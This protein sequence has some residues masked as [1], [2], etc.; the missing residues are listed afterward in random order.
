MGV[1]GQAPGSDENPPVDE[2]RL[3]RKQMGRHQREIQRLRNTVSFRLGKH[4]TDA[5]RQPWRMPLLP[6]TFPLFALKLGLERLGKRAQRGTSTSDSFLLNGNN[7]VVLFPTNGVGFGH[8]TRMYAMAR[9]LRRLDP[10]TEI[11][12]FTPM[13][14]LHVPYADG[15]ATYHMAG[16]Y[17]FSDMSASTWNGLVEEHLMMVLETHQPKMFVFDGAY[18]YRG[19][20]NAIARF[21]GMKRVWVRRGMFRK[22]ASV[23]VDSIQFFD[24]VVH[25]GDAV[26]SP[27]IDVVDH[28]VKSLNVPP[29]LMFDEDQAMGRDAARHRLGLPLDAQ[30]WYLQLGAGQINDIDSEIRMTV[31]QLLAISTST[32]VVIGE[33]MLGQRV[34]FAHPRVRVLRDYPNSMY[35]SAFDGAIQAGGYNSFHEMRACR[36]P[37]LFF[38]NMKT[39]M[40]DQLA[41]CQV[42]VEEGW[43]V[44]VKQRNSQTIASGI[45]A[46]QALPARSMEIQQPDWGDWLN[47]L[48]Q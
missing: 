28:G 5:V 32:H 9:Q 35:F 2:D 15:F 1:N 3:V 18:P 30:V 39:G 46:L 20:L 40:D 7:C 10:E 48:L 45:S 33:S 13:P 36:M 31:E 16:R 47:N 22:G 43:G 21:S 27:E 44:V 19:M 11:V 12:M 26:A 17:K 6:V 25:P 42:A 37:T 24:A 23:P 38:P 4:L 8:F 41:R 34:E 14:T 29:M